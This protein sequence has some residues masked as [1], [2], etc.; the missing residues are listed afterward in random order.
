MRNAK[1]KI[2]YNDDI[3]S[4]VNNFK[5]DLID[6]LN[7][8]GIEITPNTIEDAAIQNINDELNDILYTCEIFDNKKDFDYILVCGCLG[9]WCGEKIIK[10]KLTSL[11]NAIQKCIC[12][13]SNMIYFTAKNSTIN[14]DSYHHDG[15]NHFKLYAVKNGKKTAI[16]Y[17]KIYN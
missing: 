2:I 10:V 4:Y 12:Y 7:D 6:I 11:K 14:I 17:D 1:T 5:K 15:V 8:N 13:D 16:A 3:Y 9:L